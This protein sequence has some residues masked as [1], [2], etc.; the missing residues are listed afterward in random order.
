M[1]FWGKKYYRLRP[2]K[3]VLEPS[4]NGRLVWSVPASSKEMT[5]RGQRG[6]KMGGGSKTIFVG[7]R[8]MVCLSLPG[9]F[10]PPLPLSEFLL[11][12]LLL[13]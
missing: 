4:E 1:Q 9:V 5:G 11:T 13:A 12:C 2:P 3:P 8:L 10:H 6:G 7:R